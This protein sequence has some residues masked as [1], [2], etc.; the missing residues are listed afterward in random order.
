M[1]GS[2]RPACVRN[3]RFFEPL[4]YHARLHRPGGEI[5]RHKGLKIPRWQQRAGSSPAPGTISFLYLLLY[6]FGRGKASPKPAGLSRPL[7]A[8]ERRSQ[9]R[10]VA[11][12]NPCSPSPGHHLLSILL[13]YVFGC[14]KA[15]PKPAGLSRP[16]ST[17]ERRSQ[18]RRGALGLDQAHM[19]YEG[20]KVF[21][22]EK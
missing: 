4:C 17:A 12:R 2:F 22:R 6:A 21:I 19:V 7:S 9:A 18:I 16:L 8:A 15:L 11:A 14:G 1:A 13:V 3:S 5:G 20:F 10:R